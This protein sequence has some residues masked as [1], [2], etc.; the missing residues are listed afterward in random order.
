MNNLT[1][2]SALD[3]L[4][5]KHH[6]S[7][8]LVGLNIRIQA[9]KTIYGVSYLKSYQIED[10]CLKFDGKNLVTAYDQALDGKHDPET[11]FEGEE[12]TESQLEE[13]DTIGQV[14][15]IALKAA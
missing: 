9:V 7:S 12:L 1:I 3:S 2:K 5:Q 11:F 6:T 14:T 10:G 15:K 8:A 4:L 13:L